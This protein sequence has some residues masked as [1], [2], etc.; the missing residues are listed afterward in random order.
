MK[1]YI[2]S[3]LL[4]LIFAAAGWAFIYEKNRAEQSETVATVSEAQKTET[5]TELCLKSTFWQKPQKNIN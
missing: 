3:I 2:S 4:V 1:K 5:E